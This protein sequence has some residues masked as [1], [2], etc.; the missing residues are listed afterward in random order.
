MIYRRRARTH[1]YVHTPRT[2]FREL[3]PG[4]RKRMLMAVAEMMAVISRWITRR[5]TRYF[6]DGIF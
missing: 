1:T 2:Y 5:V 6:I 3:L 4:I